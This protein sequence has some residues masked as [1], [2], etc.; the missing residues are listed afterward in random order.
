V[1]VFGHT[2]SPGGLRSQSR[3]RTGGAFGQPS[4]TSSY[5]VIHTDLNNHY[6]CISD[7]LWL[8]YCESLCNNYIHCDRNP[9][10]LNNLVCHTHLYD[11]LDGHADF[12]DYSNGDAS[13]SDY[14]MAHNE[15]DADTDGNG[16]TALHDYGLAQ[17]ESCQCLC[18]LDTTLLLYGLSVCFTEY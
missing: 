13:L 8:Y 15:Y 4:C 18:D 17:S 12:I 14:G 1:R 2:H 5:W 7:G 16:N 3:C 9:H 11:H 6:D 10:W